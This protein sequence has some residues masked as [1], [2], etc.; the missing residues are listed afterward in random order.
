MPRS[1]NTQG[2]APSAPP[3]HLMPNDQDSNAN[4]S[5]TSDRGPP[6]RY[7]EA[8]AS[9]WPSG[10]SGAA[11]TQATNTARLPLPTSQ[12]DE[13]AAP[14]D[15]QVRSQ[16]SNHHR[17]P[18]NHSSSSSPSH[19]RLTGNQTGSLTSI[20]SDNLNHRLRQ[21]ANQRPRSRQE[22]NRYR[23]ASPGDL[24]DEATQDQEATS[25][26]SAGELK[27]KRGP[28]SKIKKGLEGIAWF[29]IQ[30]LD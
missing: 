11:R 24:S 30:I 4:R 7:E 13:N 14:N 18:Q 22:S 2:P 17:Q 29:I 8:I 28:G 19:R 3:I 6:P 9:D 10:L 23:S 1:T 26:S 27:K 25:I 21:Q 15:R 20:Q 5:S 16:P 12:I